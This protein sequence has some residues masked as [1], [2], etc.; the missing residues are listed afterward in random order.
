M[1]FD[2]R[3]LAE[4]S[5][6]RVFLVLTIGLGGLGGLFI[7]AQA[8]ALSSVIDRVFLKSASLADVTSLLIVLLLII[9]VRALLAWGGEVSAFQVAARVKTALRQRVF[10]KLMQLGP[11]YVRGE[12]TGELTN[13]AIDGI[14]ALE[15]YFSQYLPQVVLAALMP[16]TILA[17][18][19]PIDLLSGLV[20]LL[21]APFIPLLMILIGQAAEALTRHQYRAL[22]FMSAHFL[23][24]L[25]GLTTLKLL[26][27]SR[28]QLETIAQVSERFR[29]T[30]MSVLR[31]AFLSAFA[32]EMI[33]TISTAIIAVEIGLRLLAGTL[34][35]EQAFTRACRAWRRPRGY[36]RY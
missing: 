17:F 19:F 28:K 22:S 27:R 20:L 33:A 36:L 18:V 6:V 15:A 7:V 21:T 30:T 5:A 1:K 25:Q 13:T 3:L 8:G 34:L 24:V 9:I 10:D 35:V 4:A 16:L 12:R 11:A 14:E 2:K 32:L 26:G 29:D 31:V 23:D